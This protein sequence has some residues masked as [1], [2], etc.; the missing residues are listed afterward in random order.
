MNR[1]QRKVKRLNA[2]VHTKTQKI[3]NTNRMNEK[4]EQ[5]YQS[6]KNWLLFDSFISDSA[7]G[8]LD[9]Y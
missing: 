7:L 2:K 1:V 4:I 9:D 5:E 3:I 6:E 8:D